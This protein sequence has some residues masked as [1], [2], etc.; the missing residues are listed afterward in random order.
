MIC[1]TG[2]ITEAGY[3][4]LIA[5]GREDLDTRTGGLELP[6]PLSP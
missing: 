3:R 2:L 5:D 1:T 6:R 4:V